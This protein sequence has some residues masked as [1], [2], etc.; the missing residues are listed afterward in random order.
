MVTTVVKWGNSQ[1]IIIPKRYCDSLGLN[2]GDEVEL[3]LEGERMLA[4]R[5]TKPAFRRRRKVTIAELFE[6][7]DGKGY[8]PEECDWGAPVGKEMW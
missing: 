3:S 6:G 4:L 7:W 5:P 2:V 8:V 1:G